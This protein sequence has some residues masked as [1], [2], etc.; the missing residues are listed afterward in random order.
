M[1]KVLPEW[2]AVERAG[3]DW[4]AVTW[5]AVERAGSDWAAVTWAAVAKVLP[6]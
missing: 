3:S 1:T 2:G 5:A 4:A 6:E